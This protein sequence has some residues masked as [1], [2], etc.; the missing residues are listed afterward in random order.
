MQQARREDSFCTMGAAKEDTA[1][2]KNRNRMVLRFISGITKEKKQGR[3]LQQL[4]R[5]EKIFV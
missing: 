2:A 4:S 3:K 1:L 5:F